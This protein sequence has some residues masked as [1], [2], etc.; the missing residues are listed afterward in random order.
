MHGVRA[1]PP[2][3]L[4]ELELRDVLER[5]ATE[6]HGCAAGQPIDEHAF[7]PIAA[8]TRTVSSASSPRPVPASSSATEPASLNA[9]PVEARVFDDGLLGV[10]QPVAL[11]PGIYDAVLV[12]G[13]RRP[14]AR[15]VVA[16][17]NV[18]VDDFLPLEDFLE[19]ARREHVRQALAATDGNR[20]QAARLLGVDVRTVFRILGKE[21]G[22]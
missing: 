6:L 7:P 13:A 8:P 15:E 10:K 14:D 16:K 4:A 3:W 11:R 18:V 22:S 5:V 21:D 2:A 12:V 20:T 17:P 9:I 1:L 19:R